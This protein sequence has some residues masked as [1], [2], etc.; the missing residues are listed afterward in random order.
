MK[1]VWEGIVSIYVLGLSSTSVF[2]V[3]ETF[4]V[5]PGSYRQ[6]MWVLPVTSAF[7]FLAHV[8]DIQGFKILPFPSLLAAFA[9]LACGFGYELIG[10]GFTQAVS[11]TRQY[12]V[13]AM[14]DGLMVI[15]RQN[16]I[17][18][19][20]AALEEIIGQSRRQA[21]GKPINAVIGNLPNLDK[22]FNAILEFERKKYLG[23]P[24][25]WQYLNIGMSP[26]MNQ[27]DEVVGRLIVWH[28][29][30][31]RRR[32]EDA[33][34]KA[35]EEM[36]VLINA[37]STAARDAL[38]LQEFLS[39]TIYHIIY[40]FHSQVVMIFL[41]D[42][43]KREEKKDRYYLASHFGLPA[44]SLNSILNISVSSSLFGSALTDQQPFLIESAAQDPR[45]PSALQ[46]IGLACILVVPLIS[47]VGD[48]D[49]ILGCVCLARKEHPAYSQDEIVRIMAICDHLANLVDSDR[50]RKLAIAL[51]ER[52]RLLRDLHDSVS[53]KLYGLVTLTEAAQAALET[54]NAIDPLQL[55]TRIG[56]NARQAV[57]EMRLFLYQ[58]QPLDL[59][60]EGL[61]SAL[62]HRLAAVEGRANI[63]ARLLADENIALSLDKEIALYFIA[64]EALNNI[65]R[66][67]RA[68]TISVIL[69]QSRKNVI[70]EI[71][72]D[73]RGFDP[74][75]L[76]RAGWGLANMKERTKNINGK[77]RILSKPGQG[78]KITISVQRDLLMPHK[79]RR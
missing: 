1:E 32:A 36:F 26:L 16:A 61:V 58:M 7:P 18:D 59:E 64:Q 8:L 12:I 62:H 73:G 33:R 77:I 52:Q 54:G 3:L 37:I 65:L 45:V 10:Q 15:N 75:K 69:K 13:D 21:V 6:G 14:T 25:K 2:L 9:L 39:E 66:H 74:K 35:R 50:R 67:A 71:V 11:F 43:R 79:R 28:D 24:E 49:R 47:R 30:T 56:E 51:F 4:F 19:I 17:I 27:N 60:N 48:E 53:Q 63:K 31:K 23:S 42:E 29:S 57:R 72:D 44:D 40:P 5:M 41:M 76:D 20:N 78:T 68:T 46:Q 34:Q 38:N 70:L 55:L 22:P